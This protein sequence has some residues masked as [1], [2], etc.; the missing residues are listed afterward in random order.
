MAPVCSPEGSVENGAGVFLGCQALVG[1][2]FSMAEDERGPKERVYDEQISPLVKQVI[3]LCKEHNINAFMTF[4][5]DPNPELDRGLLRCTSCL[6][7][8][9]EDPAGWQMLSELHAV[10]A[11]PPVVV[12]ITVV[13]N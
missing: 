2:M 8:D 5:L 1:T 6:M 13:V 4:A 11:S 10:I 9:R 3:A 7:L 12:G